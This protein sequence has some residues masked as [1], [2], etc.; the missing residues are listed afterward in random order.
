MRAHLIV[1]DGIVRALIGLGAGFFFGRGE[2]ENR[3]LACEGACA[4]FGSG[5]RVVCEPARLWLLLHATLQPV[6][7]ENGLCIFVVDSEL[8]RRLLDRNV[9]VEQGD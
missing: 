2:L 8:V 4:A 6:N 5:F 3:Q 9:L 1:A 7:S